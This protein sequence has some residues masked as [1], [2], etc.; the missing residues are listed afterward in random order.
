MDQFIAV[1]LS[2]LW[3]QDWSQPVTVQTSLQPV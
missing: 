2:F 3:L 1:L